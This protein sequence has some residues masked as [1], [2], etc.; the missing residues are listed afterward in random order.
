MCAGYH[1]MVNQLRNKLLTL[2]HLDGIGYINVLPMVSLVYCIFSTYFT[3]HY[4]DSRMKCDFS[5]TSVST[6]GGTTFWPAV[7]LRIHR[8]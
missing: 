4:F 6:S 8:L 5:M 3:K 1:I 2:L 7:V